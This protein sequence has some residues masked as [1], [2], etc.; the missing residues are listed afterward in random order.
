MEGHNFLCLDT[1]FKGERFKNK[2]FEW[3]KSLNFVDN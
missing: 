3:I 2:G 1:N